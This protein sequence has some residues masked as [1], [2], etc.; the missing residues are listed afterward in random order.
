MHTQ[1]HLTFENG[2]QASYTAEQVPC[3]TKIIKE[4]WKLYKT[5]GSAH[6]TCYRAFIIE[7]VLVRSPW[8][9]AIQKTYNPGR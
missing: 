9:N 4:G 6:V 1:I 5:E 8:L 3:H 2:A 7:P